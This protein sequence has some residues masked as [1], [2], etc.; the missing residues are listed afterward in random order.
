VYTAGHAHDCS[1]IGTGGFAEGTTTVT[2]DKH[3]RAL[4]FST[5]ATGT[6]RAWTGG[7]GYPNFAGQPSPSMLDWY[8]N[9]SPGAFT[10]ATQ[11]AWSVTASKGYVLLGGEFPKVNGVAQ[12]GLARFAPKAVAPNK[13][14]PQLEADGM[15]PQVDGFWGT[16]VKLAWPANYDRDN[17]RLTYQVIRDGRTASPV[18]QTSV[19]SRFWQRPTIRAPRP[20]HDSHL[21]D[22][23]D[24]SLRQRAVGYEDLVHGTPGVIAEHSA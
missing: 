9:L 2:S 8:P 11:A 21:S 24:R 1:R 4:A 5:S 20:G 23:R 3:H 13:D 19:E 22:P 6:L 14:R 16:Y 17:A 15:K 7:G 18:F 12:R 10:G